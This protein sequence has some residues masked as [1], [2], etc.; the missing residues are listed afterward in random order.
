MSGDLNKVTK[1]FTIIL[2]LMAFILPLTHAQDFSVVQGS[3][4]SPICP[5]ST[6]LINDIITNTANQ[7]LEFTIVNTGTTNGFSTTVPPGFILRSGKSKTL[8]S[9]VSP[10]TSTQPGTYSLDLSV[11]SGSQ[12]QKI[13][14][15]IKVNDCRSF[16]LNVVDSSKSDCPADVQKFEFSLVNSG[17]SAETYDLS[18]EGQIA[19]WATLSD[20]SITLNKE[21]SKTIYVY[22]TTPSDALGNYDFTVVATARSSKKVQTVKG[23]LNVNACFDYTLTTSKDYVSMCENSREVVP[24]QI[25]NKGTVSNDYFIEI[26]GPEW[27]SLE[28]NRITI[29]K[30]DSNK[31]NV[32]LNPEYGV[33]GDFNIIFKTTTDKGSLTS[34]N[35]FK[36]NVKQC[37]GIDIQIEKSQDRI[38]NSLSNTYNVN[39]KNTGD[40][41]K[42]Y[43]LELI[44]PV[45][46]SLSS[47]QINLAAG[48]EKQLLLTINPGFDVTSGDYDIIARAI[49]LD[50]SKVSSESKLTISTISK[51]ECY[52]PVIGLDKKTAEVSYDSSTT[53]PV[54][55][56]NKG[57]QQATYDIGISGTASSFIHLNP[58]IVTIDPNK[59]EIIYLYAAPNTETT[60]GDYYATISVRLKDSTILASE[61]I[62]IT[63]SKSKVPVEIINSPTSEKKSLWQKI[64]EFFSSTKSTPGVSVTNTTEEPILTNLSE[65]ENQTTTT[66]NESIT[67]TNENNETSGIPVNN[68]T[69]INTTQSTTTTIT[70][71]EFNLDFT[72]SSKQLAAQDVNDLVKFKINNEEHTAQVTSLGQNAVSVVIKS[73]PINATF[74]FIGESQSFDIDGD[75]T[76]DLKVT[77]MGMKDGRAQL[78]YENL[79]DKLATSTI[80]PEVTSNE[81]NGTDLISILPSDQTST[82]TS[83]QSGSN[84]FLAYFK[85]VIAGLII[86]ILLILVIKYRK[87]IKEFFEEEIE[88]EDTGKKNLDKKEPP[89]EIHKEPPKE[90]K[91]EEHVAKKEPPKE[92]HKESKKESKK[93]FHK[94]EKKSNS[95]QKPKKEIVEEYY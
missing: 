26:D 40:F 49:A 50:S 11:Q 15:S 28:N 60:D 33:Q 53:I 46:T 57:D 89:K 94:E 61:T 69:E 34:Q 12:T 83:D 45:W 80:T 76:K 64:V 20:T 54:V 58:A 29:A 30:D 77:Y 75:G 73:E 36:V 18:L 68:A 39:V 65:Q 78:I 66:N 37:H 31:V 2:L 56:E 23:F 87:N 14:H 3:D 17:I 8:Y 6:S 25:A 5:G 43:K 21:E 79:V 52:K 85:Y 24:V 81:T 7:D 9:Y 48:E 38:C 72:S 47:G 88:E 13:S 84:F 55:I 82:S 27:A 51:E 19:P 62:K 41:S 16:E 32:V 74:T 91:K 42:D 1:S 4:S 63:V 67:N 90:A 93:E 86:L 92:A 70:G 71:L 44:G 22:I 59:A 95:K 35:Q 10:K